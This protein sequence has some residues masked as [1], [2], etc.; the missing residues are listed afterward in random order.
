MTEQHPLTDEPQFY[1]FVEE[2]CRRCRYVRS[3][4]ERVEGWED[5]V[6]ITQAKEDG[7]LTD[8]AKECDLRWIPTLMVVHDG[9][10]HHLWSGWERM[11]CKWFWE[12]IMKMYKE[13]QEENQ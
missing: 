5:A 13:Q 3:Q 1:L 9:K 2:G 4:L 7:E 10:A 11:S 6:I 8:F 12:Q